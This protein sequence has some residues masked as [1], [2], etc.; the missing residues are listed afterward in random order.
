M[1][2]GSAMECS[3]VVYYANTSVQPRVLATDVP[4]LPIVCLLWRCHKALLC[5]MTSHYNC[6]KYA[7]SS[8]QAPQRWVSV[9]FGVN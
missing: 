8:A 3:S 5:K 4:P 6:R 7:E 1:A 2:A 9:R